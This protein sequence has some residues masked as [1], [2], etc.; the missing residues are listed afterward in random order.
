[1]VAEWALEF[2]KDFGT[3][4]PEELKKPFRHH[5]E[6]LGYKEDK[7]NRLNIFRR[8]FRRFWTDCLPTARCGT[9]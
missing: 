1:L 8:M 7:N 3:K 2:E 9:R 5:F 4:Q 6:K